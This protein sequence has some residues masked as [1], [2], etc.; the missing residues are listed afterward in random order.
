MV[1]NSI[2]NSIRHQESNTDL[3]ALPELVQV[4]LEVRAVVRL[5]RLGVRASLRIV[6]TLLVDAAHSEIH[7]TCAEVVGGD[8]QIPGLVVPRDGF[9]RLEGDVAVEVSQRGGQ[10]TVGTVCS[11]LKGQYRR[12]I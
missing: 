5:P 3:L 8:V 11:G 1:Y 7:R 12:C 9:G 2:R 6:V 4:K 10:G